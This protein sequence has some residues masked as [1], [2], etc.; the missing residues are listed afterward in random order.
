MKAW[1]T[2]A[3]PG[4][5]HLRLEDRPEPRPA[6]GEVVVATAAAALN[7][8]DL[9]VIGGVGAWKP[10]TAR[11]PLSDA[12]GVVVD[13]GERVTRWS[14]GDRVVSTF[15]PH[16]IDGPIRPGVLR[17]SLG[18]AARDGVLAERFVLPETALVR[19]PDNLAFEEAATLPVAALTAWNSVVE[20]G[21]A[22]P[23]RTVVTQGTGG[24]GLFAAQFGVAVGARVIATTSSLHKAAVLARLGVTHVID[25][26]AT[27]GWDTKVQELTEGIGA[28]VVVDVAGGNLDCAM[29][30]LAVG[31]VISLVGNLGGFDASFD[32]RQIVSGA[33][34]RDVSVGSR[35]MFERMNAVI[36]DRDVHPVID[37]VFPFGDSV[38]AME[39][40]RCRRHIGKVCISFP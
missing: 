6:A 37:R 12:A 34:I 8:R 40:F 5:D 22:G 26:T 25:R 33:Q 39:Y 21:M 11:V 32:L 14:V 4:I 30:S 15:F 1:V 10:A 16:W 23:G 2:G 19:V 17:N 31:G 27:P 7:Y 28:D 13:V 35:E 24:V 36:A 9:L 3:R 29:R 38:A 20:Q 18:G